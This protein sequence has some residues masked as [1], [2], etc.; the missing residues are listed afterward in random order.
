MGL[1]ATPPAGPSA[2][3]ATLLRARNALPISPLTRGALGLALRDVS[4]EL[5]DGHACRV[6][7]AQ[8]RLRSRGARSTRTRSS[9]TTTSTTSSS[10]APTAARAARASTATEPM[11]D[12][13]P[14]AAA[15][16]QPGRNITRTGAR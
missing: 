9:S 15:F 14:R 5:Y 13:T 7:A 11:D 12:P 2:L 1:D 4:A 6:A 3:D 16:L 8:S 10:T